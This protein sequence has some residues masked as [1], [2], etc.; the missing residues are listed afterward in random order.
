M[1]W[2]SVFVKLDTMATVDVMRVMRVSIK[3]S[4]EEEM[5]VLFWVI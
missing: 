5:G 3:Q 1:L 2:S 4:G